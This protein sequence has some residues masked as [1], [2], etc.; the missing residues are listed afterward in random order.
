M[1]EEKP[2]SDKGYGIL[3]GTGGIGA[4]IFFNLTGNHTLGRDES[5]EGFLLDSK[6]FC[7]L[8]IIEHYVAALLGPSSGGSFQTVA[9]GRVGQDENGVKLL[10]MM[11]RTG[12][13]VSMVVRDRD[14]ATMFSVCFQ[15]PDSSGGNITTANSASAR[16]TRLDI[17]QS[18][19]LFAGNAGHGIALAAPETPLPAR[20]E[21][22][23]L[24]RRY[25]FLTVSSFTSA[26][27]R[28]KECRSLLPLTDILVLNRDEAQSLAGRGFEARDRELLLHSLEEILL[29]L[30]QDMK[31]CLTLGASGSA[32]F[33]N[34]EWEFTPPARVKAASTAGAGDATTAGII[35]A[36]AAGL[37]F[38]ASPLRERTGLADTPLCSALDFAAL[39]ASLSVTSPDTI[40]LETSRETLREHAHNLGLCLSAPVSRLLEV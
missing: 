35:I 1:N 23:E 24:A 21:L 2:M 16:V 28:E 14:A 31:I 38:I 30:R 7:K 20:A 3:I 29:P 9:L 22:L 6:D 5:R 13:D 4:G 17:R 39:L 33:E 18:I 32:G 25:S 10:E 34:G 12:I 26:E 37:P 27:L 11:R 36:A 19:P 15:Y 40:H 8:H